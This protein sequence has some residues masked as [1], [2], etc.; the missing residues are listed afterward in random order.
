MPISA[1]R[2]R[3]N[4]DMIRDAPE[5]RG[6]YVLWSHGVPLMVGDAANIRSRLLAHHRQ[7]KGEITHYSWEIC[8]HPARRRAQL[9]EELA[10]AASASS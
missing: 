10:W 6:V 8:P 4:E 1:P 7:R 3:F 2:W 9:A 5:W